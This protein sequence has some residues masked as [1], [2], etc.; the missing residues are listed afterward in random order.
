VPEDKFKGQFGIEWKDALA[1]GKV[2]N[3]IDGCA[4]LGIDGDEMEKAW[5]KCKA[6]KKLIKF[7]GGFYCGLIERGKGSIVYLQW[8]LHVHAREVCAERYIHLLLLC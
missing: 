4:K 5:A 6:D 1:S 3:A 2:F 8:L 7:G